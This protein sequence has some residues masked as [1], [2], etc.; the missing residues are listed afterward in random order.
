MQ[1]NRLRTG[2]NRGLAFLLAILVC[3][4]VAGCDPRRPE[5]TVL[6]RN[7]YIGFDEAQLIA[8]G[9]FEELAIAVA[10]G[11]ESVL[12]TDFPERAG[13]LAEEI[14]ASRPD[15]VG[16]QEVAVYRLQSPGDLA[17]GGTTPASEVVYDFLQILLDEL[18]ARGLQYE[19]VVSL[20]E[21][22]VELPSATGDDVRLTD[23]DVILV[24]ADAKAADLQ[25]LATDA[26]HFETLLEL[27][28]GGE[29]GPTVALTRGWTSADVRLRGRQFRF[30]N[31]HLED[32]APVQEAQALELLAGPLST[33]LPVILVGD[34]N[35][36]AAGDGTATYAMMLEEGFVDAWTEFAP[37]E[38]GLTWG[39][40]GDLLNP[41]PTLTQRLDLILYHGEFEVVAADVVGDEPDDRTDSGLWPSD[42]AGVAARLELPLPASR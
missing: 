25:V 9:S 30:V 40:D 5:V 12:G 7:L 32:F 41:L 4:P 27:P 22:D 33:D 19:V 38:P 11:W 26:G 39:H 20:T 31:T 28:V 13:A 6:T 18:A 37:A 21:M 2:R 34:L 10:L 14:A 8:A 42:H 3:T 36:D 35:S 17:V 24:R 16:L 1:Q 29:G 15:L 23:R